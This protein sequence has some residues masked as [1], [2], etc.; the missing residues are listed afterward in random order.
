MGLTIAILATAV[1]YGFM[2]LVEVYFLR[3]IDATADDAYLLGGIEIDTWTW[4]EGMVGG[5]I[6]VVC[7]LA[8]WGR[9]AQIRFVL[10][11]VL[12][13]LTGISLYRIVEA[14]TSSV[15]PIFGGQA[16]SVMRNVLRCQL[17]MMIIVP[18]YVVWYINRAPARAFYRQARRPR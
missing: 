3:R 13:L 15:D 6:L 11:G 18:L 17:P 12:L 4:L 16:Q 9:P 5:I 1:L 8:W 7:L 10:V 2:P 14:W